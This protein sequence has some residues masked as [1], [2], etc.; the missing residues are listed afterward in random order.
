MDRMN[1]TKFGTWTVPESPVDIEYSFIVIDEIRQVVAEGFQRLSRGGIEVGG[2]LYGSRGGRTGRITAM[3]EIACEHA[4]GPT[5]H[6]SRN[7]PAPLTQQLAQHR[8]EPRLS[9]M[10]VV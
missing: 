6:L 2:V 8:E 10:A 9:G 4:R 3:R 1:D 5:F 7:D